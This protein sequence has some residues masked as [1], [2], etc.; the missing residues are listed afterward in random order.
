MKQHKL[1]KEVEERFEK[2][3][4][5]WLYEGKKA[6]CYLVENYKSHLAKELNL[7]ATALKEELDKNYCKRTGCMV[8]K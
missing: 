6:G 4:E 2:V 1:T 8:C 3:L 7:Q 5:E